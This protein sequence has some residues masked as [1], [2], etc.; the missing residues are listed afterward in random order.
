MVFDDPERVAG[1]HAAVL[2]GD[3]HATLADIDVELPRRLL[4]QPTGVEWAPR[5]GA[6]DLG[7]VC[8]RGDGAVRGYR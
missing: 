6:R 5:R 1:R 2:F 4:V 8:G 7:S 3:V